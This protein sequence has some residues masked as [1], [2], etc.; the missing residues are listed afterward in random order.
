MHRESSFL[1]SFLPSC[2]FST[3]QFLFLSGFHHFLFYLGSSL[4]LSGLP[5][6][7][8]PYLTCLLTLVLCFQPQYIFIPFV[9][10][11]FLFF[12]RHPSILVCQ[13]FPPSVFQFLS[14]C[15][16]ARAIHTCTCAHAHSQSHRHTVTNRHSLA[17]ISWPI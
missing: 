15:D 2:P 1:L 3:Y 17:E 4:C 12:S 10:L 9:F 14:L 13:P 5:F 11:H 7:I 16:I 8:S 6:I